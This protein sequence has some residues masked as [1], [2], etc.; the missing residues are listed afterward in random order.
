MIK[1][2]RPFA[3]WGKVD[4]L[5]NSDHSIFGSIVYNLAGRGGG[6]GPVKLSN[7]SA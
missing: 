5:H 1:Y 2:S 3:I 7:V 6:P 4:Q